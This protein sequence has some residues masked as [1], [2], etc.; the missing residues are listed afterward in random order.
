MR[1]A[2][3]AVAASLM[4]VAC[5][6]DDEQSV[7]TSAVLATTE[8]SDLTSIDIQVNGPSKGAYVNP[9]YEATC[10]SFTTSS[11]QELGFSVAI[12]WDAVP[13]SY[14]LQATLT[15]TNEPIEFLQRKTMTPSA[16]AGGFAQNTTLRTNAAVGNDNAVNMFK[17][18]LY[19]GNYSRGASVRVQIRTTQ[20]GTLTNGVTRTIELDQGQHGRQSFVATTNYTFLKNPFVSSTTPDTGI[21]FTIIDPQYQTEITSCNALIGCCKCTFT[22]VP[23]KTYQ[24]LMETTSA[25]SGYFDI[26]AKSGGSTEQAQCRLCR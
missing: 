23:G 10:F 7:D 20:F 12:T 18:C 2:I 9:N 17:F 25:Q 11:K 6:I 21:K 16:P 24:I 5:G 4:F 3:F 19:T 15:H 26:N 14:G 1:S 22:S 8:A 13:G